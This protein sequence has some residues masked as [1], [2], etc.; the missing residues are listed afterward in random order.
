MPGR[1]QLRVGMGSLSRGPAET[2]TVVSNSSGISIHTYFMT[3]RIPDY[4]KNSGLT[5][6]REWAIASVN[7]NRVDRL[8]KKGRGSIAPPALP[9]LWQLNGSR[10][11]LV[12][13]ET[14]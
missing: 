4:P 8:R 9:G 2:R 14:V 3:N 10:W 13:T 12:R 11:L 7:N 6:M 5:G 1:T